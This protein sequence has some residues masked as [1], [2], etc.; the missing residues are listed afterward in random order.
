MELLKR[1]YSIHSHSGREKKMIRFIVYWIKTNV[2]EAR[3][4]VDT[5]GNIFVTKGNA[6]TYPCIVAHI[7]EVHSKKPK[8][9]KVI[10]TS[11]ILFGWSSGAKDFIGIGADDKSGVWLSLVNLKKYN[12]IKVA[13]FVSEEVGCIGSSKCDLSFFTNC[14]YILQCDRRGSDDFITH[15]GGTELCSKEFIAATGFE[16]YGYHQEMGMMTDAL[17]LKERGL[18][19][20][21]CNI[22]CGYYEPHTS[23]EFTVKS[24]L[25]NCLHFVEHII[26]NCKEVYPHQYEYTWNTGFYDDLYDF[27]YDD[28]YTLLTNH[29]DLTFEEICGAFKDYYPQAN[30]QELEMTYEMAKQDIEYWKSKDYEN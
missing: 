20:S 16:N 8:D 17:T 23:R 14:R 30:L 19:V 26:E 13:L 10:E 3:I 6:E 28:V 27:Y 15:I 22:S 21:C 2:K 5:M 25:L 18:E 1:L 9:F 7:D 11:E 29:P 12:N 4:K 24:D